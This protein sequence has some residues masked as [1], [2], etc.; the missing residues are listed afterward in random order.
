MTQPELSRLLHEVGAVPAPAADYGAVVRASVAKARLVRTGV[1]S[2][3]GLAVGIALI[4]TAVA[5][6]GGGGPDTV[7]QSTPEPVPVVT[8][9][10]EPTPTEEP[11][12]T[13]EPT[14]EPTP[15]P[16][17]TTPTPAA[18]VVTQPPRTAA[19]VETT[20]RP[21]DRPT[22]TRPSPKP[23]QTTKSPTPKPYAAKGASVS[24]SYRVLDSQT[25]RVEV[26]VTVRDNDGYLLSGTLDWDDESSAE[27]IGAGSTTC[28]GGGRE[29]QPSTTT[30]TFTR[31]YT[32]GA[33][34]K[35]VVARVTTGSSCRDTPRE[36]V[37]GSVFVN[38]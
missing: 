13:A 29:A 35:Q 14:V 21:T 10:E 31:T 33:E 7:A 34:G 19:P 26:T 11:S 6:A 2:G 20:T 30:K 4:G 32:G 15:T 36:S 24:V 18:P 38:A 28:G 25:H 16:T 17:A 1:L 5:L 27:S 12:P 37:S 22:T 9:S 3:A 23:V 8:P